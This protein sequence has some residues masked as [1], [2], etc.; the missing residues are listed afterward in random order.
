MVFG[1]SKKKREE[2]YGYGETHNWQKRSIFWKLPYWSSNMIRHNLDVMH[3]E[4]NNFGNIFYT[5]MDTE[6]TKDNVKARLDMAQICDRPELELQQRATGSWL[7]PKAPFCLGKVQ[8]KVICMWLKE[9]KFPDGYAS[10]WSRSVNVEE[11]K[12]QGLKSHDC[13]IFM[14]RLLPVVFRD[15]LLDYIWEP[16][17]ELSN[18][19]RDLCATELEVSHLEGLEDKIIVTL[20]KLEQICATL[21]RAS[22]HSGKKSSENGERRTRYHL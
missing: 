20:C 3:I 8:K 7:K 19:F 15:F 11:C 17:T 2:F 22:L 18:F 21:F 12:F 5:I 4:A 1:K 13:H 16:L 6:K 14:E 9:L 10:N